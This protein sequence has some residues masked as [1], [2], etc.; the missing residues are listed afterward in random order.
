VP[1]AGQLSDN[2]ALSAWRQSRFI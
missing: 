1:P 2:I